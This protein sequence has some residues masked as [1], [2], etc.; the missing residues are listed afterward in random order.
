MAAAAR[1]HGAPAA[2]TAVPGGPEDPFYLLRLRP[3]D[4]ERFQAEVKREIET[5]MLL[6]DKAMVLPSYSSTLP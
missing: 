6:V 4:L 3:G 5:V 2:L 1:E